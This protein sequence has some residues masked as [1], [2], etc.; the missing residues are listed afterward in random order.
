MTNR[1]IITPLLIVAAI[2]GAA[3]FTAQSTTISPTIKEL[4][5]GAMIISWLVSLLYI[6]FV[7]DRLKAQ[8]GLHR[9]NAFGVVGSI[10]WLLVI[11][12]KKDLSSDVKYILTVGGLICFC[13][14]F[15]HRLLEHGFRCSACLGY[16]IW[17]LIALTYIFYLDFLS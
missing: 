11:F 12:F 14:C 3:M 1:K 16:F 17:C 4:V 5:Y 13:A 8:P 10:C 7:T 9:I 15:G 6:G 2:T